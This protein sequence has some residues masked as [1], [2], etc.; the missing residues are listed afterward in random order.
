MAGRFALASRP[1]CVVTESLKQA[2]IRW[3]PAYKGAMTITN[4]FTGES[5]DYDES[6]IAAGIAIAADTA[7][8][9]LFAAV[10]KIN[11]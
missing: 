2:E 9:H 6:E 1:R 11:S 7:D 3:H 4:E 5:R 8:G 10:P